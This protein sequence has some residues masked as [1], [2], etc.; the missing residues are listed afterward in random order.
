MTD[1]DWQPWGFGTGFVLV[2][3]ALVK[4]PAPS[5]Q[6]AAFVNAVEG[7]L[8]LFWDI[9]QFVTDAKTDPATDMGFASNLFTLLP[10]LVNP[11]KLVPDYGP[12]I[13]ATTDIVCYLCN[14]FLNFVEAAE[15]GSRPGIDGRT[16]ATSCS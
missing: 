10:S 9:L 11:I 3:I 4:K 7:A 15:L 1:L 5:P 8:V 14:A 12:V 6:A 16:P 13:A 2:N